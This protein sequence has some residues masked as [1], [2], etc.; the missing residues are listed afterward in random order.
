FRK[1]PTFGRSTIRRFHTNVS[2]MRKMAAQDF[3][4]ILQCYIPVFEGLLPEPHNTIVLDLLYTFAYWHA[5]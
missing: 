2:D 5:V 3:E 4:D 1:L